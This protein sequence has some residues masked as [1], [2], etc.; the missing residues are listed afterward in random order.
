[1][2]NLDC[3]CK[4]LGLT[5]HLTRPVKSHSGARGKHS[6]GQARLYL[7]GTLACAMMIAATDQSPIFIAFG[8]ELLTQ[9]ELN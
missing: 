7:G 6:H 4:C 3:L 8:G 9:L 1:M 5:S 2:P